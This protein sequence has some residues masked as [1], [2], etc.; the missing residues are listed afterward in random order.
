MISKVSSSSF[1]RALKFIVPPVLLCTLMFF[2]SILVNMITPPSPEPSKSLDMLLS[3]LLVLEMGAGL[4]SLAAIGYILFNSF[5]KDLMSGY[6]YKYY[7]LPYKK[8]SVIFSSAIPA[9][10]VTCLSIPLFILLIPVIKNMQNN[11]WAE[12]DYSLANDIV[13]Y[14]RSYLRVS[15]AI[16]LICMVIVLSLVISR[17]FKTKPSV[18]DA[19]ITLTLALLVNVFIFTGVEHIEI[20]KISEW[21]GSANSVANVI[22]FLL[23]A[24]ETVIVMSLIK[25]YAD[26]KMDVL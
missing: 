20:Y 9:S 12:E 24:I 25:K 22:R 4:L 17:S 15:L 14:G 2:T 13:S 11:Q 7:S 3:A 26:T 10:I 5:Y 16:F 18:I 6:S 1:K 23:L 19:I 8:S 21:Y